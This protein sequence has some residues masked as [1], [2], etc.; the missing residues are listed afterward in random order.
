MKTGLAGVVDGRRVGFFDGVADE[1]VVAVREIVTPLIAVKGG[2][3]GADVDALSR[4]SV[5]PV[6]VSGHDLN[7]SGPKMVIGVRCVLH[8]GRFI[9]SRRSLG[10]EEMLFVLG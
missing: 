7:V 3:V 10:R 1:C 4:P 2:R 6:T 9:Y 5:V 8:N